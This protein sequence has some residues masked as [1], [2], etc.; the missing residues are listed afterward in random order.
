LQAGW[1]RWVTDDATRYLAQSV[2]HVDLA[3][4]MRRWNEVDRHDRM[5]L[6]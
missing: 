1:R 5:P 2:D 4:R 6:L 3:Y